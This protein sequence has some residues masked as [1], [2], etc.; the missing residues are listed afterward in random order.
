VKESKQVEEERWVFA[1]LWNTFWTVTVSF[2]SATFW[3][4]SSLESVGMVTSI[5]DGLG[6]THHGDEITHLV[7]GMSPQ[8]HGN[9]LH[10]DGNRLHGHGN[11][12]HGH[13]NLV[14]PFLTRRM[15]RSEESSLM[16][17]KLLCMVT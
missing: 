14:T 10:C 11:L 2:H 1:Y 15:F 7:E 5:G 16:R 13:G 9:K 6:N 12:L 17:S 3:E 8:R 4:H